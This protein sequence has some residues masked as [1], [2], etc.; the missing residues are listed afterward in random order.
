M[1][2]RSV[3]ILNWKKLSDVLLPDLSRNITVISAPNKTGKST[4]V[5]AIRSALV[6]FD[7]DTSHKQIKAAVPWNTAAVP[8]AE[9][10]FEVEGKQYLLIKRFASKPKGGGSEL[11]E[12]VDSEKRQL[13]VE[14]KE[15]SVRVQQLLHIDKSNRGIPSLLWVEQG[16]T[17]LPN[18]DEDLDKSLRSVLGTVI[19]GHDSEFRSLLWAKM[20]QWF[21][22][23]KLAATGTHRKDSPIHDVERVINEKQQQV[24]EISAAFREIEHLLAEIDRKQQELATVEADVLTTSEEMATL[25][26]I[27]QG[28]AEKRE[29]AKI[30]ADAVSALKKEYL[31]LQ[32]S[33]EK[34]RTYITALQGTEAAIH[35]HSDEF[36]A[37][38]QV[39]E[40]A[41]ASL[42]ETIKHRKFLEE[43][44]EK[45]TSK[46]PRL[47]AMRRL[48]Q[49]KEDSTRAEEILAKVEHLDSIIKETDV[50]IAALQAPG[51]DVIVRIKKLLDRSV[52]IE[53]ELRA[54]QLSVTIDPNKHGTMNLH[55]DNAEQD[56]VNLVPGEKI[57]RLVRQ[58]I[59]LHT[60]DLGTIEIVRGKEDAALENLAAENERNEKQL[61][62]M[63]S[64]WEADKINRSEVIPELKGR[65]RQQDDLK[66]R[67]EELQ[68]EV[69][70]LAPQGA[71]SLRRDIENRGQERARILNAYPDLREWEPSRPSVDQTSSCLEEEQNYLTKELQFVRDREQKDQE[72]LEQAKTSLNKIEDVISGLK[73]EHAAKNALLEEHIRQYGPEDETLRALETKSQELAK[74][75]KDCAQHQLT[76]EE[77]AIPDR[78]EETQAALRRR[79]DRVHSIKE[80]MAD[81]TGQ[82][83]RTEGLHAKRVA[84][85]QQL[86][87][88]RRE[89]DKIKTEAEAH[90]L[91]LQYFDEIRDENI[92]KSIA[93][94]ADL[95][96]H[97]QR[98]LE[99]AEGPE[100]KFGNDLQVERLIVGNGS[101]HQPEDVTSYGELEQLSILVRLAYGAILAKD[102]PQVVILDDPLAHADIIRHRRMLQVIDDA[103]KRNLQIVI[104]TC[105]PNRFDYLKHAMHFDLE[106][107]TR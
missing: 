27:D 99:S 85:E 38:H 61:S 47:L 104:L 35:K 3:H 75:E 30:L 71:E 105:H 89:L 43:S 91:L 9:I 17:N 28:L 48:L 54:G 69:T 14:G 4:L 10:A 42:K 59:Q 31:D 19:T 23:E 33:L 13:L 62:L 77:K 25:K 21:T 45:L 100:I 49:I 95:V 65:R 53:A 40:T 81:L 29:T 76:E 86:E 88:A 72:N 80:Q 70:D 22:S 60:E 78:L 36:T 68:K 32:Q 7:Y 52:Q 64:A 67:I 106:A 46:R 2:L 97:W 73:A 24:Q 93:P 50:R 82:L 101:S 8:Q 12:L 57:E 55:I 20:R 56:K 107:A 87:A 15:T 84:A 26:Q 6:D 11:F 63:L 92:E 34:H 44:Q 66:R 16:M 58:R 79:E 5:E 39:V 90:Q 1:I 18:I 41:K 98:E 102:E 103:A 94:V 51:E 83:K 74:A 37:T 96:E